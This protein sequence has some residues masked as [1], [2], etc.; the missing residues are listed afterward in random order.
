MAAPLRDRETPDK[1]REIQKHAR[2]YTDIEW[3]TVYIT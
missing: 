3:Y 2:N 1:D